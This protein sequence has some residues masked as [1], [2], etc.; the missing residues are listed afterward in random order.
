MEIEKL[1]EIIGT[2][3][4]DIETLKRA[5]KPQ[6]DV[7]ARPQPADDELK[8]L[9]KDGTLADTGEQLSLDEISG[10]IVPLIDGQRVLVYPKFKECEL[11]PDGANTEGFEFTRNEAALIYRGGD[12]TKYTNLLIEHGSEAAKYVRNVC[13]GRP[14][15]LPWNALILAALYHFKEKFNAL[16]GD[17]DGADE[18]EFPAWSS[19]LYSSNSAWYYNRYGNFHN[20][21]F[22]YSLTCVPC[23]LYK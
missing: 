14:F 5:I 20:R 7:E 16:A 12:G 3:Q 8:V 4:K 19:A 1:P 17:I 15:N 22:Y 23:V 11:L 21:S 18:L 2:M 9:K 10:I 6:A 13:P